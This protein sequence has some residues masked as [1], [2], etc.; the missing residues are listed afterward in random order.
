MLFRERFG[1]SH[2]DYLATPYSHAARMIEV[3]DAL[4]KVRAE[5]QAKA[6]EK[7][8]RKR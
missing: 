7:A 3:H 1:G 8:G 4:Q 5:A 6:N 2:E